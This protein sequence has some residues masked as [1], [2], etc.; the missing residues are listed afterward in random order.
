MHIDCVFVRSIEEAAAASFPHSPAGTATGIGT[1]ILESR[2]GGVL[3]DKQ[4][5]AASY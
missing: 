4:G 1:G 5:L 2:A 3:F